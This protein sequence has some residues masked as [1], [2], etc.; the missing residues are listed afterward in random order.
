MTAVVPNPPPVR[1]FGIRAGGVDD[2][3]LVLGLFDSAIE[4]MVRNDLTDQWGSRRFS[5]AAHRVEMLA[6]RIEEGGLFLAES[7]GVPVGALVI[8]EAL[9]YVPPADRPEVYVRGLVSPPVR[10]ARGVGGRLLALA[11]QRAKSS[12]AQQVRVDCFAGND[13]RLVAYYERQGFSRSDTFS[14]PRPEG[15]P[16]PGQVLVKAVVDSGERRYAR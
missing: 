13:G 11:E 15:N 6:G 16:W 8:G 3:P 2:L 4:W 5:A 12:G 9:D 7:A 10:G 14:I 1:S